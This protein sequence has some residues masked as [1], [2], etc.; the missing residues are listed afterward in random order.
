MSSIYE[1]I[2]R[3]PLPALSSLNRASRLCTE[4]PAPSL[5]V[6]HVYAVLGGGDWGPRAVV[7]AVVESVYLAGWNT[8]AVVVVDMEEAKRVHRD[9]GIE[10]V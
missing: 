1:H 4:T 10:E 2:L 5:P 9:R 6:P 3:S 8:G 7:K